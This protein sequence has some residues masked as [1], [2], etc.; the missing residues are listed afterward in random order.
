MTS[1]TGH[2]GR[3]R[4]PRRRGRCWGCG[5]TATVLRPGV[6]TSNALEWGAAAGR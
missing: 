4:M 6:V 1:A 5:S 3:E 2:V